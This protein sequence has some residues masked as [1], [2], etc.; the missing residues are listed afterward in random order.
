[1]FGSIVHQVGQGSV[2]MEVNKAAIQRGDIIRY[3]HEQTGV[4]DRYYTAMVLQVSKDEVLAITDRGQSVDWNVIELIKNECEVI[5]RTADDV[6][7]ARGERRFS[8]LTEEELEEL[9]DATKDAIQRKA[10]SAQTKKLAGEERN[11]RDEVFER[12][13]RRKRAGSSSTY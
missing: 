1:M 5:F 4:W 3:R 13:A 9:P 6:K 8:T 12:Q 2:K 7:V 10:Q 11:Y